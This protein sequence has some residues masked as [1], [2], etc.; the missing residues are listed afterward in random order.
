MFQNTRSAVQAVHLENSDEHIDGVLP[1][2][3]LPKRATTLRCPILLNLS[4]QGL[5]EVGE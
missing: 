2:I 5:E 4:Y 3:F 1:T